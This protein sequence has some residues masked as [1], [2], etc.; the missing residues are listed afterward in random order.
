MISDGMVELSC[1]IPTR[2]K[3]KDNRL[4][5]FYRHAMEGY[6]PEQVLRKSK[7]GFGLPFGVWMADYTP[8]RDL[9]THSLERQKGAGI[10][11]PEFLDRALEQHRTRHAAY[12]GEL[13]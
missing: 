1:R 3:L 10:F 7:H 4:R 12:Y 6:L 2:L 11:R 13:M 5:W 9:A 8:L